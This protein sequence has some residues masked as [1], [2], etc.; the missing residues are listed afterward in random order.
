MDMK[1]R[2][3]VLS[4]AK[5]IV[6]LAEELGYHQAREQ[7]TVRM[8]RISGDPEQEIFIAEENSVLGWMHIA[9]RTPLESPAF[10]EILGFVVTEM[11]RGKGAGTM[12]IRVAEE[13]T[14]ETGC[15]FIRV[16]I[17][18]RRE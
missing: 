17:N 16:R 10:V 8:R 5:A 14:R 12:L 1:I 7:I 15:A 11:H 13:W 3:A 4:D 18:I 2:K 9:L 6:L